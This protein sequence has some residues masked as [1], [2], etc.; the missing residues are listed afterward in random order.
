M[1]RQAKV[2]GGNSL[3]EERVKQKLMTSNSRDRK[4]E[5]EKERETQR[6]RQRDRESLPESGSRV[7]ICY[8]TRAKA[9]ACID[10]IK[11]QLISFDISSGR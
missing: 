1:F 5:T 6:D 9:L 11:F 10:L 3:K 2:L 7:S 4:R 8:R